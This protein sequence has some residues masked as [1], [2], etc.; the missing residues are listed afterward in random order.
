M[1]KENLENDKLSLDMKEH[2]YFRNKVKEFKLEKQL[3][4]IHSP[5]DEEKFGGCVSAG[6]GFAHVTPFGDVTPCPVV[7]IATHNLKV[8]NLKEALKSN[9]FK[10]IRENEKILETNGSPC[11]LNIHPQE[12]EALRR[13]SETY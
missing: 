6:R 3:F 13:L 12:L 2:E 5:G 9:L 11:A 7:N 10:L 1:L 4:I 8:S